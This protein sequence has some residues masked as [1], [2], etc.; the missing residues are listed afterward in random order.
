VIFVALSQP[1]PRELQVSDASG[2]TEILSWP[3]ARDVLCLYERPGES[4]D[5]GQVTRAVVKMVRKLGGPSELYG[6]ARAMGVICD[7]LAGR[8]VTWM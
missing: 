4:G 5:I 1:V 3:S 7:L 6:T 2:R 8:G